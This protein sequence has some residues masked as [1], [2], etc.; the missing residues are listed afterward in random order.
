MPDFGMWDAK[1]GAWVIENHGIDPDVGM[2]NTQL[3]WSRDTIRSS[4]R[5][6][7]TAWM[8]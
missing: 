6:S 7:A 8:S 3:R 4:R 1:N 5:G 2:E